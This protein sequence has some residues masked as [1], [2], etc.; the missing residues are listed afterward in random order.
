[1]SVIAQGIQGQ[2]QVTEVAIVGDGKR[3]LAIGA[4][5]SL[6]GHN[7]RLWSKDGKGP[8]E[9][10]VRDRQA[11]VGRIRSRTSFACVTNNLREATTGASVVVLSSPVT[12]YGA[13]TEF[14]AP[15]LK[16]GQTIVLVNAPLGGALQFSRHLTAKRSD[17]QVNTLEMGSLFDYVKI[18]GGV[19]LVSGPRKRVSVCGISRNETHR[20]LLVTRSL[21]SGLVPTSNILE[22]GFTEVERLLKPIFRLFFIL[23]AQSLEMRD[24][25]RCCSEALLLLISKIE[26]EVQGVARAFKIVIPPLAQILTEYYEVRGDSFGVVVR[27]AV[28]SM[29]QDENNGMSSQDCLAKLQTEIGE[30]FV[31]LSSLALLARLPVPLI[32]S[33]I[34][35]AAS[36]TGHDLRKEGSDL[37][38]LGL[39][40]FDV[41]EVIELINA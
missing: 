10:E 13:I 8:S 36:V 39:L 35:L 5:L 32:D 30:T 23:G 9:C 29:L 22:R 14:L 38:H 6:F 27:E 40:G 18:E 4:V 19:V 16:N 37:S 21:W 34:E 33:V 15:N 11:K 7:V 3:S 1:M 17:L 41:Q 25:S 12:E 28:K 2:S 20:G 24:V 26:L 31:L